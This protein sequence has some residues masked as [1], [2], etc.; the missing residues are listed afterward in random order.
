MN[1][2]EQW[3]ALFFDR[4]PYSEE[5]AEAR[6]KIERALQNKA[7][8]AAPDELAEKYG[9]Y[10]KLAAIGGYTPEDAAGWLSTEALR[11]RAAIKKELRQQRWRVYL[12]ALLSALRQHRTI[13]TAAHC[14]LFSAIQ[15]QKVLKSV[16]IPA[17]FC[18]CLMKTIL[19]VLSCPI[20]RCCLNSC[21]TALDNL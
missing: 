19:A 9:S 12:F 2:I 20:V 14:G 17:P 7:P 5:A 3:I 10:E 16:R 13:E 8:D 1:L 4:L 15:V 18:P 6:G 11:D 21:R